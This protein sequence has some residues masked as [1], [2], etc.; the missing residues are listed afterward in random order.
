MALADASGAA[1]VE[2]AAQAVGARHNGR[3]AG[4]FGVG[5]FSLYATKNLTTGEG[6]VVTTNDAALADRLRVLRNQGMRERYQYEMAGHNYRLTN[7]AAAVGLPQLARLEEVNTAAQ[8][9]C[10]RSSCGAGE[11]ARS[12]VAE[13]AGTG[14]H[15]RVSPVHGPCHRRSARQQGGVRRRAHRARSGMRHLLPDVS[16]STTTATGAIRGWSPIGS[17]MPNGQLPRSS[18]SPCIRIS[19]SAISTRSSRPCGRSSEHE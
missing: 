8:Q 18:R 5:C 13:R 15:P 6:G 12:G 16:S 2:D 3:P 10:R 11:R 17:R 14:Q 19:R 4:S 1:V 7:L 9:E